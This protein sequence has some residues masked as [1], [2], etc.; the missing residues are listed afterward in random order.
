MKTCK[1]MQLHTN[2][3]SVK[4][5]NVQGQNFNLSPKIL[6]R[7]GTLDENHAFTEVRVEIHNTEENPFPMDIDAS[8]TGIFE[9]EGAGEDELREFL[10]VE[11]VGLILPHL[12]GLIASTTAAALVAPV[13]LPIYDAKKLFPQN[14]GESK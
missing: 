6:R 14:S 1:S 2:E 13:M 10:E 7:T 12:R 5:N 3:I 11:A 9:I 8:M 4:N